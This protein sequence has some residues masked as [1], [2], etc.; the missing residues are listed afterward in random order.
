MSLWAGF[1]LISEADVKQ[2]LLWQGISEWE[3][4]LHFQSTCTTGIKYLYFVGLIWL[5]YNCPCHHNHGMKVRSHLFTN[6]CCLWASVHWMVTETLPCWAL[7]SCFV[8]IDVNAFSP[9]Y[10]MTRKR[11]LNQKSFLFWIIA[12]VL[13]RSKSHQAP[14]LNTHSTHMPRSDSYSTNSQ[15]I[16][17]TN[18][19]ELMHTP[20]V[21]HRVPNKTVPPQMLAAS[22]G[23]LRPPRLLSNWLQIHEFPWLP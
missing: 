17:D 6:N 23:V 14:L 22:F 15:L 12:S 16:A 21:K 3:V 4:G 9:V 18:Y 11:I 7:S 20:Q 10:T 2:L 1:I 8:I 13:N 19:P 5:P